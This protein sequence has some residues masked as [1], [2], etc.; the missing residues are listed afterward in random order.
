M[1]GKAISTINVNIPPRDVLPDSTRAFTTVL[2]STT[3]GNKRLFGRYHAVL[4]VTYGVA[5]HH[6]LAASLTFWVIPY[7]LIG[8]II[9]FIIVAFLI[10]RFLI[11]RYNRLIVAKAQ[12]AG[13]AQSGT[14]KTAPRKKKK[15]K[16]NIK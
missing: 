6:T 14:G 4:T 3:I 16:V 10:L 8:G 1:F 13:A 5:T 2:G 12:N 7:R 11:K 15:I 9:V